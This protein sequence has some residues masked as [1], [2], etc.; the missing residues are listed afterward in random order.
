MTPTFL[1]NLG[2][3][4]YIDVNDNPDNFA[5]GFDRSFTRI[6]K[7]HIISNHRPSQ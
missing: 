4:V 2:Q 3:F 5:R 1:I 6:D 7:I